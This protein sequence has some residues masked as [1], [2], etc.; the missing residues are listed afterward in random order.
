MIG[1][2]RRFSNSGGAEDT[3]VNLVP[4]MNL[5]VALI[6]FL[7]MSAAFFNISVINA[8]V[9]ALGQGKST[10]GLTEDKVTIM[11]QILPDGFRITAT[12]DSLSREKLEELRVQIPRKE[13]QL[14]FEGFSQFL[15][16]CKQQYPKSDTIILVSDSSIQYQDVINTMDASGKLVEKQE[17]GKN[18]SYELF[19]TIVIS[20][21]M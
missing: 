16:G 12:S 9:P 6:P 18:V 5:F 4:I 11:A 2:K 8:S 10:L 13:D 7:L 3:N 21:M 17:D 1:K 20:G 15:F 14:D 19:P